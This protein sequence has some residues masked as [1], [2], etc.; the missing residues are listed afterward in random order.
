[1]IQEG[2]VDEGMDFLLEKVSPSGLSTFLAKNKKCFILSTEIADVFNNLLKQSDDSRFSVSTLCQ[3]FSGEGMTLDFAT[4]NRRAIPPNTPFG[5]LG[6]IQLKPAMFFAHVLN[7]QC[8]GLLDRFMICVPKCLPPTM[9]AAKEAADQLATKTYTTDFNKCMREIFNAHPIANPEEGITYTFDEQATT[10]LYQL[11][12]EFHEELKASIVE[13]QPSPVISKHVELIQRVAVAL[14]VLD[15]T[16]T[17]IINKT[18]VTFNTTIPKSAVEKAAKYVMH[19]EG[20][21]EC[22][23]KVS[24]YF[25]H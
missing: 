1:M 15:N 3:L 9:R 2:D 7:N 19:W 14:Y 24:C 5:I 25:K 16:L 11:S 6:G 10:H 4:Q 17:S 8:S 13:S 12:D 21:K 18:Q 22:I 20:Q 23:T